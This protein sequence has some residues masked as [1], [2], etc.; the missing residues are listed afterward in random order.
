MS[1]AERLGSAVHVGDAVHGGCRGAWGGGH[2]HREVW[3]LRQVNDPCW[4]KEKVVRNGRGRSPEPS[5]QC[6]L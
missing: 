5:G 2:E 6:P 1:A 3:D 4:E